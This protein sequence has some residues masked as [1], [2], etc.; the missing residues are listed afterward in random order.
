MDSITNFQIGN[1]TVNVVTESSI[2]GRG[3][4]LAK[5][6]I[7]LTNG[8][9]TYHRQG[10]PICGIEGGRF[11]FQD[12]TEIFDCR[13]CKFHDN[14]VALVA[15]VCKVPYTTAEEIVAAAINNIDS[16][17][18]VAEVQSP[19]IISPE[20]QSEMVPVEQ[21]AD[22]DSWNAA[23]NSHTE[24]EKIEL[25]RL[26]KLFPATMAYSGNAK[27][28][29][30]ATEATE[31]GD[32]NADEF[33]KF[34]YTPIKFTNGYRDGDHFE[35]ALFIPGDVDNAHSDDPNDWITIESVSAQLQTLGINH[36]IHSSRNDG[37]S[38]AGKS[39]RE[40]SHVLLPVS[41]PL[42]NQE[43]YKALC[44]WFIGNFRGSDPKVNLLSQLLFGFG[45][46][47]T[48]RIKSYMEG[49]CIDEVLKDDDLAIVVASAPPA[50]KQKTSVTPSD[51]PSK[52]NNSP[53]DRF[54]ESG[55]WI[56][57]LGDLEALG[58]VFLNEKDG[59]LFFQTPDGDHSPGKHDGNIKDGVAFFHSKAPA[60]FK[61]KQGYPVYKLFTG[62]LFGAIDKKRI[63][64]FI[65][66][67]LSGKNGTPDI[68]LNPKG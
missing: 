62:A 19:P 5:K 61:E 52:R 55:E 51:R 33:F 41:A 6:I 18:H 43:K 3:L 66:R 34:D 22:A 57:R 28:V 53:F 15:A 38:K 48:P 31:I 13:E 63:A 16:A 50:K 54:V 32:A 49:R 56:S 20:D 11:S 8:R 59:Q 21:I 37:V 68:V 2:K 17:D 24:S 12:D 58:W 36:W 10:C 42:A 44:G 25:P 67:Y 27:N 45:N 14:V 64:K 46:H 39:A 30:F 60:P 35:F 1:G 65:E 47:P 7:G 4:D 26:L 9:G 40:K 29:S 23:G